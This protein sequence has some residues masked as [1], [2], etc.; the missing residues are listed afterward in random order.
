MANYIIPQIIK[1]QNFDDLLENKNRDRSLFDEIKHLS[2]NELFQDDFVCIVGEPGV[3]KTRLVDEIKN[4]IPAR[5]HH[6]TASKFSLKPIPKD[7]EYFIIDALDEVEGNVFYSTLQLIKQ[8]KEVN[9]NVKVLFTCRKHYVASYA[10]F[11][12]SCKGLI[13]IELCRLS[14]K[15][16]M[17]IVN[18]CSETTRTNVSK[19][20]KLKELLTI[21]RYLTF[22]IEHEKQKGSCSNIG[23]L[24]E[25]IIGNSIQTAI[26]KRQD[27]IN[28]QDNINNE[29]SRIL[30]QRVLEKVAFI[31]EISRK[32]Q[33]SKDELYTILDE[34]K[35]NMAQLLVVNFD[36]LYFESR[37]LKDT[38]G[39]LQFENT[40]LQEYLA[41]KELCRQDNIESVLYDVAVQKDL[42]HIYPNWYDVIPHISYT[43]DEI[44]TFINVIKLIVSYESSLENNSFESLLRYVDPSVCTLHQKEELFSV[45]LEHYL[46]VPA[47]IGWK[48][49]TVKL[50]RGCYT[51][52]CRNML[53]PSF[54]QLNKIQLANVYAI[55]EEI[56][57]E[58]RLDAE[59][60]MYWTNV[61]NVLVQDEDDE[62]KIAAL[63]LLYAL[64]NQENLIRLSENYNNYT[65]DVKQKYNEVTG[66]RR[67]TDKDVVDCWL[68]GC[69]E[70]NPYA[71]NAVLC[72]ENTSAIIYA[73]GSIVENDKLREFFDPQG[74][75]LVFF[76]LH[77]KNQFDIVWKE[78]IESKMLIA[79]VFAGYINNH[80]Y[81]SHG[82]IDAGVKQILL[83][84]KTGELFVG[85]FDKNEW[86]LESFFSRF[87]AK[88]VDA[89]LL[90]ALDTLLNE[91]TT[92]KWLV[93][94][95]LASLVYKI[96]NDEV[97]RTSASSYLTRY[98]ETFERWDKN[99]EEAKKEQEN[100]QFLKAYE[101]LSDPNVSNNAKFETAFMLSKNHDFIKRQDPHPLVDVI[102]KFFDEFDLDKMIMKKTG[103]NSFN[104]SSPLVTIPYFVGAMYYLG[105]QNQLE[106]HRIVL[107]KTLPFVCCTTNSGVREIR[108][109]YKSV[110]GNISE[111]EKNEL[112]D[113][114][115]SRKDDLMNISS[116]DIFACIADYGIDALSYKLEEY[117][118]DYIKQQDLNH[119]LAASKALDLITK[120]YWNW[121]VKKYQGLFNA[122]KDDSIE[123]IKMQCNAIM[124]EKYQDET[125]I[126]WRIEY[127]KKHVVKSI[128]DDTC[129]VRAISQEESEMTSSNPQM[130]RCFMNIKGN[131]MLNKQ[132]FELFDFALPLCLKPDTQEYSSYLL[133]QIYHFFAVTNGVH[134]IVELRKKVEQFNTKNISYLPNNIMNNAEMMYLKNDR[135]SIEKSIRKYNKCIEESYL[136]IRNNGDLR[137]YFTLIHYEVQK[138]IQDQGIY[139]LVRQETL[140]EDFIQR[141]LK[142]TIINKCCQLGLETVRVDRE[143]A[144][145]D[146]KR[147]D[148]LIRYGLC[149]PIM[150]ELK[151]LHNKEIQNKK[152]RQ[153]YKS[154][155]VQYTKATN[156]CLS[157]FWVFNVH[158]RGSNEARF[159]DLKAEYKD[160]DNTMVLLTDCKC[161]CGIET[162]LPKIK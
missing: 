42:K 99:S 104:L 162:G 3:G 88:L 147:T 138:E 124:I 110:I 18:E 100:P 59:V 13:F 8:Y 80:S 22:L 29:G 107:A 50:M 106:Q 93:N 53:M 27:S 96:R 6:C 37:I 161:S 16:V 9:P 136:E 11:F 132:M 71:I 4:Q 102:E 21:P 159:N 125:A 115:Q 119:W 83:E 74:S 69:Y 77:L 7:I 35:G 117:I 130:F 128:H 112:V 155:L 109:I 113:W 94:K 75:L 45:L 41:A 61:A 90:S 70:R 133:N 105:F 160:L 127:V 63:N 87:D 148:L 146:N 10:K 56:N 131:E 116:D 65:L 48:S 101:S 12:A 141:E 151:L 52:K 156:A 68:D 85:C 26:N 157:V 30:I 67:L 92:K 14:D 49:Q 15:E 120:G 89:E 158:K 33:I 140:S 79:K 54:V 73:Y 81:T 98:A 46:R 44:H 58:D 25:F 34:I 121:D 154:K 111:K 142:N 1:Y 32:D 39:I 19:S 103:E 82:E 47:Y 51:S 145:Q 149:N 144:L 108:D 38:N 118:N 97:K 95:I 150:V 24:F 2:M 122:L 123:S 152:Q 72:I 91:T 57:E 20:A 60:S 143:V 78:D 114:W 139:A 36:L 76:E 43:K 66:Y 134:S 137:R 86:D 153:E 17:E 55:L 84:E 126:S 62:K 5:L 129:H 64:K 23:E 28:R 40:E 135:I 31:M